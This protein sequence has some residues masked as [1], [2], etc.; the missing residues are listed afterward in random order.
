MNKGDIIYDKNGQKYIYEGELNGSILAYEI[1]RYYDNG[2]D[3][4]ETRNLVKLDIVSTE[5]P[6]KVFDEEITKKKEEIIELSNKLNTLKHD[7]NKATEQYNSITKKSYEELLKEKLPIDGLDKVILGLEGKLKSW[8]VSGIS[9]WGSNYTNVVIDDNRT[10]KLLCPAIVSESILNQYGTLYTLQDIP[11]DKKE[12]FFTKQECEQ[13]IAEKISKGYLPDADRT[14]YI[15][16]KIVDEYF[17]KYNIKRPQEWIE[18]MQRRKQVAIKDS[19][20]AINTMK[21]NIEAN[22]KRLQEI[23]QQLQDLQNDNVK[24]DC[25]YV[26]LEDV[27]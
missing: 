11:E 24:L 17:D 16:C 3:Y 8:W 20:Q 9:I 13:F 4:E 15:Q 23:E 21:H 7:I 6:I 18:F 12:K 25:N 27:L 1:I 5:P 14:R 10:V 22:E 26:D 2:Y 19:K